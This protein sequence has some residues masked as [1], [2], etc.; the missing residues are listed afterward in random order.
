M[1]REFQEEAGLFIPA[2]DWI[3][4]ITLTEPAH[5]SKLYVFRA[6]GDVE[7]AESKTDEQV[8][9]GFARDLPGNVLPS[10]RWL[11]PLSNDRG[12]VQFPVIMEGVVK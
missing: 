10:L 9:T 2:K 12:I 4:T 8:F 6:D 3:H 5:D 11:V 7:A 1:S